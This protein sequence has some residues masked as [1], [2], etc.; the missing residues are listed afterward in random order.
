VIGKFGMQGRQQFYT[1][2]RLSDDNEVY[3]ADNFM[4][5]SYFNDPSSFRNSRFLQIETDS[6]KQIT[7]QY[8][9]DSSFILNN[10]DSVWYLG[11]EK[12][13][14]AGVASYLS[15]LR[16]VSSSSFVDDVEKTSLIQPI[17]TETIDLKGLKTIKI[18]AYS[19]PMHGLVLH[20][21]YNPGNYFADEAV[22]KRIFKGLDNF[23]KK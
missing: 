6:V 18:T 9:G 17:Y 12:A 23:K 16:Y 14:S 15:Q 22:A 20:S 4:G 11:N 21:D 8:P 10:P 19:H 13:D 7:F 1:Y 5:I 2:V 3:S